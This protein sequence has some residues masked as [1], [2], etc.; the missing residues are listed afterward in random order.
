MADELSALNLREDFDKVVLLPESSRW[1]LQLVGP[2]EV[3]C[4]MSSSSVP[5][6]EFHPRLLWEVYPG[7]PASLK[8]RDAATERL[9][10]PSAWPNVRGF[11]PASLDAC[12]N[13][14]V[15]G[16]NLHPEWRND[17]RYRWDARGNRLLFTLRTLQSELDDHFQGRHQ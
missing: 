9:D 11:R 2:L 12:V 13:W 17:P 8:F 6:E 16:F 7:Q 4:T 1:N 15:E 10:L 14:T 3:W 5:G